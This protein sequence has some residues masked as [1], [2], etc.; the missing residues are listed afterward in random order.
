M[1]TRT[2]PIKTLIQMFIRTFVII[3]IIPFKL[4]IYMEIRLC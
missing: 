3:R 1:K 2:C 4:G